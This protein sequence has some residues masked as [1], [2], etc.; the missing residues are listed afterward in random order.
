MTAYL[1]F[2]FVFFTLA[3]L[4][5]I[6]DITAGKIQIVWALLITAAIAVWTGFLL[7]G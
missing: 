7:F 3:T 1:W 5:H 6:Y 4:S 2:M